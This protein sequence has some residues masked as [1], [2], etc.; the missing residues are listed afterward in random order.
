MST[1]K[2]L[3]GLGRGSEGLQS[4]TLQF[5]NIINPTDAKDVERKK[6]IRSHAA[7]QVYLYRRRGSLEFRPYRPIISPLN[8]IQE[9]TIEENCD[10]SF[11]F[12]FDQLQNQK[13]HRQKNGAVFKDFGP[14]MW[15]Y[16]PSQLLV[17]GRKNPFHS[18]PRSLTDVEHFLIDHCKLP[19]LT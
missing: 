11:D 5:I 12:K 16:N 10:L 3:T 1:E 8:T 2:N 13:T 6:R 17:Q 18:Y 14:Q 19:Q 7:K 15:Y 9:K 4:A